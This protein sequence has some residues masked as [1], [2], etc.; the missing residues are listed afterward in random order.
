MTDQNAQFDRLLAQVFANGRGEVGLEVGADPGL[1]HTEYIQVPRSLVKKWVAR[2]E[3]GRDPTPKDTIETLQAAAGWVSTGNIMVHGGQLYSADNDGARGGPITDFRCER[4]THDDIRR[5]VAVNITHI[6]D[7]DFDEG[8]VKW[9]HAVRFWALVSGFVCT[10]KSNEFVEVDDPPQIPD[11]VNPI[12]AFIAS[13]APNAW[14]AS[15]ARATSWR[16]SNHATGGEIATG[17]P[18]RWL[19]KESYWK[20]SR[21]RDE[22]GR[23]QRTVTSAFYIATHASAVHAVLALMAASVPEHWAVINPKYGFVDKWDVRESTRIRIAPNT[24]VAGVAMVTDSMV[25]FKMLTKEGLSPLLDSFDSYPALVAAHQVV[26]ANG[27]KVASYAGWFL[28]GHPDGAERIVFNQKDAA[29]AELVG[30]LGAAATKYYSQTTIG[31]SPSLDNASRQMCSDMARTKWVQLGR[32]KRQ[33]TATN[34]LQAYG[35]I[36]GASASSRI[37]EINSKDEVA[38]ATAV[39]AYNTLLQA[40][41]AATGVADC[42]VVTAENVAANAE[43]ADRQA[44]ALDAITRAAQGDAETGGSGGGT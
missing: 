2:G 18:R 26:E 36:R 12:A 34:I 23:M 1:A 9:I 10:L 43:A 33:M 27:I 5:F 29:Y 21:N 41:A 25:C 38:R 16:K 37:M 11:I 17:F 13:Y 35:R 42:P 30:E 44:A 4:P 31:E 7:N 32:A 24:Q 19:Q 39:T 20:T 40:A 22:A 14:T 3:K 28:A 6:R 8:T 15:A